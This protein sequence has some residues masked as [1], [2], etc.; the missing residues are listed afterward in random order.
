MAVSRG[1]FATVYATLPEPTDAGALA[2]RY[3]Q[4]YAGCPFV[5]I[6]PGSP[7]LE[8]VVGSNFCDV[9]VAARG[10]QV[11]VMSAID[12]LVKGM[13]GMAIQNMNLMCGLAETLGLWTPSLRPV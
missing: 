5:R 11:V 1:I 2:E 3:E 4:F 6:V 10:R 13:A 9:G 12:N 7:A 8:D